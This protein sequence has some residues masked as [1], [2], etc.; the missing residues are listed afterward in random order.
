MNLS[1]PNLTQH[2]NRQRGGISVGGLLMVCVV[3]LL[4]ALGTVGYLLYRS[5]SG[6][7]EAES[8]MLAAEK[9]LEEEKAQ[10]GRA[11]V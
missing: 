5:H 2:R 1:T 4:A 7:M 6:Q 8:K 10:I 3:I 11:H 9:Q